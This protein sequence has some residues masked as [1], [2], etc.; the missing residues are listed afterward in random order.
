MYCICMHVHASDRSVLGGRFTKQ[1]VG[2]RKKNTMGTTVLLSSILAI[3]KTSFPKPH[4]GCL[5]TTNLTHQH[6]SPVKACAITH[7]YASHPLCPQLSPPPKESA[8]A[9]ALLSTF[10]HRQPPRPHVQ[11]HLTISFLLPHGSAAT[12][13]CPCHCHPQTPTPSTLPTNG[14][15]NM[16]PV[17]GKPLIAVGTKRKLTPPPVTAPYAKRGMTPICVTKAAG[18]D[19]F[20]RLAPLP[21]PKF[22]SEHSS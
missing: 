11:H 3:C 10:I 18:A 6:V 16:P 21:A 17:L 1:F 4:D 22:R 20:G 13:E 8:S 7:Q 5:C 9:S 14:L 15:T 2:I 12:L 19:T